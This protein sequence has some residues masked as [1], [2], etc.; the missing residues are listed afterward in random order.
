MFS[1]LMVSKVREI[2]AGE[3]IV[4]AIFS[5]PIYGGGVERS[6]TEGVSAALS[7]LTLSPVPLIAARLQP[8]EGVMKNKRD[9]ENLPCF[10]AFI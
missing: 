9:I 8:M 1:L 3:R 10:R 4:K 2:G 6:E 5:S 7:S